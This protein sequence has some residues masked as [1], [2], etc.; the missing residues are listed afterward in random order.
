MEELIGINYF[1]PYFK[2]RVS[3]NLLKKELG[4]EL[5]QSLWTQ[6]LSNKN[7]TEYWKFLNSKYIDK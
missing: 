7:F 5:F 1:K 4:D 6:N 2:A 3:E